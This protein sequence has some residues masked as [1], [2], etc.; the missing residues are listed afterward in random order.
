MTAD[1][2]VYLG[3]LAGPRRGALFYSLKERKKIAD[4]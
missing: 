2:N 3:Y 4:R 1:D